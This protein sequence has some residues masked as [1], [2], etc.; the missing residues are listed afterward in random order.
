MK[1]KNPVLANIKKD[2]SEVYEKCIRVGEVLEKWI[3]ESVPEE[4]IGFL[5]IHFGAAMVRL[6]G[7]REN[8]RSVQVG[9]VCASGIGISRLMLNKLKKSFRERVKLTAYGKKDLTPYVVA[10]TDFLVTSIPIEVMEIPVIMVNP[11]LNEEDLEKIERQI[12]ECERT[13]EDNEE[14]DE[15]SLELD[16]VNQVVTQIKTILSYISLNIVAEDITFDELLRSIGEKMSPY[17]DRSIRI[18]EDVRRREQLGTQIFAEFGFALLHARTEGVTRPGVSVWRPPDGKRFANPVF[19]GINLVLVM[20]LPDDENRQ[21][22]SDI[23]GYISSSL[24]EDYEFLEQIQTGDE[25]QVKKL[26]KRY[27]KKYFNQY[28]NRM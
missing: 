13:P 8:L 22:N 25:E 28:L 7:K 26:L 9:V 2:Y 10:H 23:L 14:Q 21:I 17:H 19:K 12:Y 5:A 3:H 11:L 1:I 16:E 18:Q 20:L 6:E 27:L 4:E 15:F 24:I